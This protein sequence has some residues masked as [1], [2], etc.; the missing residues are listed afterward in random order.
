MEKI[1]ETLV[2]RAKK[3]QAHIEYWDQARVDEMVAAVG[4]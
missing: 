1:I 4:W 2:A 3:A